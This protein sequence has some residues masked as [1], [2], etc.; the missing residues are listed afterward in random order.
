M[1]SA[2]P[3]L[4]LGRFRKFRKFGPLARAPCRGDSTTRWRY[5]T[6]SCAPRRIRPDRSLALQRVVADALVE[7]LGQHVVAG[8]KPTR[9]L[10]RRASVLSRSP[11]SISSYRLMFQPVTAF[12]VVDHRVELEPVERRADEVAHADR[13]GDAPHLLRLEER[14]HLLGVERERIESIDGTKA[15]RDRTPVL[16][17]QLQVS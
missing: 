5:L 13:V 6:A 12:D 14:A 1:A 15:P 8:V 9:Q 3:P 2:T 7:P 16:A 11:T 17:V 4:A 10:N